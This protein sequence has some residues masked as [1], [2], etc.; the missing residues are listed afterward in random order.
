MT[1]VPD[2]RSHPRFK[3][4]IEIQ[5]CSRACIVLMGRTV[6]ISE[7]GIAAMIRIDVPMGELV[8]LGFALPLGKVMIYALGRETNA[9]RCGFQFAESNSALELIRHTCR[10]LAIDQSPIEIA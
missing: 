4:E 3:L 9:F 2:A 10:D 6:D 8:K 5:V 7:S 1:A